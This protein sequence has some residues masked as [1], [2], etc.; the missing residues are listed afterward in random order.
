[1]FYLIMIVFTA[2]LIILY[3]VVLFLIRTD[4]QV[5][6][7]TA[8]I[9]RDRIKLA[10]NMSAI[11]DISDGLNEII[12]VIRK[13]M[14]KTRMNIIIRLLNSTAQSMVLLF[15]K[16]KYKKILVGIKTGV[17]VARKFLKV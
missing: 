7:V 12:P 11:T 8:Q 13:K 16:P 10:E 6:R 2:E 4:K 3:N 9:D 15:F 1:M 14:R 17:G 5:C